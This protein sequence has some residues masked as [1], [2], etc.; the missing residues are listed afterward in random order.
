MPVTLILRSGASDARKADND[1]GI[2][3]D[4]PRIVLGRG[5]GCDL[6]LPDVSVSHRHASLR[7]SGADYLVCDEGSNNGTFLGPVRLTP[8]SPRVV[9]NGDL[10]RLGRVWVEVRIEHVAVTTQTAL[11][12]RELALA[13]V[14]Q[15]L[16]AQGESGGPRIL[17]IDGPDAEREAALQSTFE[18][19]I[20][21]RGNIAGLVLDCAETSRRHARVLR[22]SDHALLRDLGS[23]IGTM[24]KGE[25]IAAD[26]D[27]MLRPGDEFEIG[28]NRF[29]FEFPAVQALREL[30]Q[31]E[32]EAMA[33]NEKVPSLEPSDSS[34]I[35]EPDKSPGS[36]SMPPK[37]GSISPRPKSPKKPAP[38]QDLG[39]GKT[40]V[41]I[42]LVA[43]GVLAVSAVGLVW[44]FRGM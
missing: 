18:P 1:R 39:W 29:R 28:P 25:P 5:E 23:R 44:L 12:T 15:A 3:Y 22:Q 30:E 14:A 24:F 10:I 33:P 6:R 38:Q 35:A 8:Q 21:G 34:N 4:M 26:K 16:S 17:V 32:V 20:I 42:V 41:L 27:T 40:D 31:A 36:T 19:L 11:A 7:Q 13:V 37:S 2:T 9:R 43:V